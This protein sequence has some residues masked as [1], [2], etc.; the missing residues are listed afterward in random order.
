MP[1]K[2]PRSALLIIDMVNQLDFPEGKRL[3]AHALPAARRIARLRKRLKAHGVP[4][5]FVN[6][7]FTH[8]QEDFRQLVAICSQPDATGAPLLQA[9]PPEPDD[10]NMLKPQHSA[11]YNSALE[12]LLQQLDVQRVILTGIAT[13]QCILA[14]ALG[15]RMRRLETIVASD[16]TAAITPQRHRNA[17]AVMRGMEVEVATCARITA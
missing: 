11:F 5:V 15:A 12:V 10:Y 2:T 3:L 6:D 17:L 8:W 13:D 4:V 16:G 14:S 1:R 7:N 9:L